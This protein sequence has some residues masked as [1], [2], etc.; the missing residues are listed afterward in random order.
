M[1]EDGKISYNHIIGIIVMTI[2]PTYIL[3]LPTMNYKL[4]KQ[5]GWLAVVLITVYGIIAAYLVTSLSLIY[6]NKTIIQY[7]ELIVGKVVGKIIGLIY[8]GYFIHINSVII[9]EF[10]ELLAG[11]FFPET[12][13]WFF[14]I[15]IVLTTTY[16]VKKGLEVIARVNQ[17]IFPIFL[18]TVLGIL[19]LATKDMNF[20]NLLP[21]M[22][23]GVKPLLKCAYP[24][25][26]WF[27]ETI[28][29]AM[30]I[31]YINIPE[32]SRKKTIISILIIGLMGVFLNIAIVSVFGGETGRL[33]Y[34]FLSL[35]RY[36]SM[37]DFIER[38]DSF[39]M[40][41]WV[42]GVFIKIS[43]FHYCAVLSLAQLL[44]FKDYKPLAAP[45]GIILVVLSFILW[46]NISHLIEEIAKI[47]GLSYSIPQVGIPLLLLIIAKFRRKLKY[48]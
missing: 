5:N 10:A 35:A 6:K 3:Y 47:L 44:N 4:A 11:P 46:E 33:T 37:A 13:L 26:I 39:I 48:Q 22:E 18:I 27:S 24:N 15:A 7:S 9:R 17:I 43:V 40:F 30:F 19:L 42:G 41:M 45:I 34:P 31:P 21:I 38:L 20:N 14:I 12:P 25:T 28:V 8:L 2:S 36:V 1:L 23:G 32:K 16:A 29:M